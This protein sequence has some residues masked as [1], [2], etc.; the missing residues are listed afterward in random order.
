M[1]ISCC[2][3]CTSALQVA[4]ALLRDLS[5][6]A[7]FS[8]LADGAHVMGMLVVL[9]DDIENL[10]TNEHTFVTSKGIAAMPFLFGVVIYCY[11][12]IGMILPIE[13]SMR[14]KAKVRCATTCL[15]LTTCAAI[16]TGAH[17][18]MGPGKYLPQRQVLAAARAC[19]QRA[20]MCRHRAFLPLA[21]AV[22]QA[23]S[24]AGFRHDFAS[25]LTR[26]PLAQFPFCC[27]R[28]YRH[29]EVPR[30]AAVAADPLFG[31]TSSCA[32]CPEL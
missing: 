24:T 7:P 4:L 19:T 28:C 12:G 18:S 14:D 10:W 20:S 13:D 26:C 16:F 23:R 17:T 30:A 11:E 5:A 25:F 9:K 29:F 8:L 27:A 32:H 22:L 31:F 3:Q 21:S 1:R 2:T 6:L 15:A